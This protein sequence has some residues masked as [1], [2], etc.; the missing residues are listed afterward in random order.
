[1]IIFILSCVT[2]MCNKISIIMPAYNCEQYVGKTIDSV[3]AQIYN[4]WELI[5]IDDG[6]TDDTGKICDKYAFNNK[7]IRVIHTKNQGV[8]SARNLGLNL[9]NGV[10]VTFL[11]SDDYIAPNMY[12]KMLDEFDD[13]IEIVVCDYEVVYDINCTKNIYHQSIIP[14]VYENIKAIKL[15]NCNGYLWNKVY[16]KEVLEK[17][18]FNSD[19]KIE[20]DWI[21][22]IKVFL[23]ASYIK[24][25]KNKYY[26]YCQHFNSALHSKN[27]ENVIQTLTAI[28]NMAN[29]I[30]D[31][32][33][34]I[35]AILWHEYFFILGYSMVWSLENIEGKSYYYQMQKYLRAGIISISRD[36]M[37]S[38][39]SK[40]VYL[41]VALFPYFIARCMWLL[42]NK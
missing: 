21:F 41:I 34:D 27:Y 22:N 25:I 14:G 36:S 15:L 28:K 5:I 16:R 29:D 2:V 26:Y 32:N 37:F 35:H 6:S 4:N 11:D 39:K 23:N 30:E 42:K 38:L 12:Q 8:S 7:K 19:V 3:I 20:E 33:G 40:T 24:F 9:A 18:E 1:M 13:S 10:F 17:I 31:I